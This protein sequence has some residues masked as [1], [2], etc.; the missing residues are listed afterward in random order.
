MAITI[1]RQPKD[2][3]N[4]AYNDLAYK[5]EST[6]QSELGFRFVAQVK[7]ESDN[8]LFEKVQAADDLFLNRVLSDYVSH[9]LDLTRL[10]NQYNPEKA[11]FKYK[12]EIGEEYFESFDFSGTLFQGEAQ[13]SNF[14]DPEFNQGL[15][16]RYGIR[17]L[18]SLAPPFVRGDVINLN[19][20][21][22]DP[23][24]QVAQF[25]R[26]INNILDTY[27]SGSFTVLVL[28]K[29][30]SF[31]GDV[32]SGQ[33]TYADGRK[34]RFLNETSLTNQ[35]VFN[36]VLSPE[37]FNSYDLDDYKLTS[38]TSKL[39][40][41]VYNGYNIRENNPLFVQWKHSGTIYL[42]FK[43]DSGDETR[44]TISSS[45][46]ILG[47]N[48]GTTIT[49]WGTV[50]SGTSPIVKSDTKF[51][52]FWFANV[53]GVKKSEVIKLNID[54]TCAI[55]ENVPMLFLDKLGSFLPFNF[56][57]MNV[58]SHQVTKENY[59]QRNG[60]F[61]A[62][63]WENNIQVGGFETY[64][65]K[66]ERNITLRTDF[67]D[68]K[69]AKFFHNVAESPV[70]IIYF[71]GNWFRCVIDTTQVEVK[72]EKWYELKR[73]ELQVKLSNENKINV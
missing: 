41:Q 31:Q 11:Y 26:G 57:L 53:D 20:T 65:A 10:N 56:T 32:I 72:K 35:I 39:L 50:L 25:L 30:Y 46:P 69:A 71:E 42:H 36:G 62:A 67:L 49:N 64:Y 47:I 21:S 40:S 61:G 70:S 13:W 4:P 5:L 51:Y 18:T 15:K 6:N 14:N 63:K 38:P 55:D 73:Y 45:N 66:Y 17:I 29:T 48:V 37:Q 3:V 19:I 2:A 33:A 12:V 34:T 23:T 52:E 28:E 9:D 44:K 43:N 59:E 27:I 68:D 24:K 7:D 1:T 54:K 58:E 22:F 8:L 16:T 60:A